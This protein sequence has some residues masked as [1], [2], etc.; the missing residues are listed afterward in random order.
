MS[1]SYTKLFSSITKSTVW[2]EP[3]TTRIVWVTM[4]AMADRKGRV[5]AS[6]PGL[7]HE[8][9]VTVEEAEAAIARF[10]APDRHSRT[11]D[12]EGRRI[13]PIDGGWRL[14]N[15]TKYREMRDEE[16]RRDYQARWVA[17]K[18]KS[19]DV[20]N[21]DQS[22][23]PSTQAAP[24]PAPEAENVKKTPTAAPSEP[25]MREGVDCSSPTSALGLTSSKGRKEADAQGTQ[26]EHP[27]P[28]AAPPPREKSH[29][30]QAASYPPEFEAAFADY[31]K[32]SGGNPKPEAYEA[33]CARR[34]EGHSAEKLND[35]VKR[36]AA[37]AR[38]DGSWDTRY[39]MQ[40]SSFFGAKKQGYLE[41]W[42]ITPQPS[43]V[44]GQAPR[45]NAHDSYDVPICNEP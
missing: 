17:E 20:D 1:R 25:A 42:T 11:K 23:P 43:G 3:H 15:H 29:K 27:A 32:R 36:Y 30:R 40:A 24:A 19:T 9:Y 31:P 39:V 34:K 12:Q 41:L 38:A 16:E 44:R 35:S 5:W 2:S 13:E 21:V 37:Y 18:R 22:R 6:V 7:A 10:L 14:L 28:A 45:P 33:W 4:L 26:G 8:A